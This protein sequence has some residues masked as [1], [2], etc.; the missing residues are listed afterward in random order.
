M[1][2]PNYV[3]NFTGYWNI[4]CNFHITSSFPFSEL[5]FHL[6]ESQGRVEETDTEVPLT[7]CSTAIDNDAE[8]K[9][10]LYFVIFMCLAS[11][12]CVRTTSRH[13]VL[14]KQGDSENSGEERISVDIVVKPV[15]PE[16]WFPTN[17]LKWIKEGNEI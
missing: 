9:L 10:T 7:L 8:L 17:I 3:L 16:L 12:V 2:V 13:C 1:S 11:G 14:F 5:A 6:P 4:W 15:V